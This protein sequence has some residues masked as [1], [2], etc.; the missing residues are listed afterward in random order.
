MSEAKKLDT[1]RLEKVV[2]MTQ[3]ASEHE[4]N[5]LVINF[6]EHLSAYTEQDNDIEINF[7]GKTY[8]IPNEMTAEV[9]AFI[10]RRG[11]TLS[12]ANGLELLRI[13]IGDEFIE[14]MSKSKAPFRLVTDKVLNPIMAHYGMNGAKYEDESKNVKTPVS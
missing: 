1:T 2:E 11:S 14:A 9:F 5:K 4:R 10:L 7:E 3:K 8:N 6:D 12:D 13:I